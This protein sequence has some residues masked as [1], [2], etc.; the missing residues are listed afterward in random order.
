M[1][2]GYTRQSTFSDGDT[3]TAALFNNEYNQLVNVFAYSTSDGSSGHRHDGTAAQGGAIPLIGDLDFLNKVA[4][5]SSNNRVG[6][7]VEVSAAAVEQIRVQDGS[8]IPVTDNDIDL[9]TSSLEFKDLY[10]DGTANI[11]SLTLTSGATATSI[12]DEDDMSSNSATALATQQSIKA[13][14]DAQLTASDLDFQGDS[15]GALSIDLDSETLDIAGGTGID[16]SGSSNTLTVAIDSTVATLTGSQTLTNKTLTSPVLNTGVSG[17][18]VLDEDDMSSD[19]AT[20]LATQQSIK[21]YVDTQVGASS[22]S[23]ASFANMDVTTSL[24]IPDGTTA[25]RP[26]SPTVGNFR[27]NTTTGG[28]EGYGASGW[29]VIGGVDD[30]SITSAKLDTNLD[31]TGVMTAATFEPDGDTAASDTAAIGYTAAEGLI[32][33]GQG[34]TSDVTFKNDADGEVLT[35]PTGTTNID[36]VGDVTAATV[37]ADGDTSS[38]DN[39]AMGYTAAEGLILTG[40]GSTNDVT[41]KND[42][43]ADVLEIPTGTTNV[44]IAGTLGVAGGSTNGVEL[45]QGAISLK[46]GGAQSKIDF[47]CESSNAHYTRVQAAP[48]SSYSGNI[49]LTLPASDG[50]ADQFLQTDG[51]GV[52]SWATAGGAYTAWAQKTSDFTASAGDQLLCIHASTAFTITLPASPSANDTVVI[53]NAGAATVTVARNSSNINSTASDFTLVQG[54]ST[55]LVYVDGTIGWFEI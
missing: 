51:S 13:Y 46:N 17:T 42:A 32:L 2:L 24:Q 23:T 35:I 30:G 49:T 11:D 52:M 7:F 39:A 50:D 54:T 25:T 38:G 34:S 29:G 53:S 18:A 20:K 9:G 8:V 27:Y 28:F 15:G 37:N 31:L 33:T 16:T 21:T 40:Q 41:I 4:I 26:S 48:H 6:V 43:D 12:A 5:D 3:I 1:A 47:Y 55:Q 44:T 22:S 10:I 36:I 19:S 45:S 14:V